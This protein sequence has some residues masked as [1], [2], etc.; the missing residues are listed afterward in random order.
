MS[1][2]GKSS[3]MSA[4]KVATITNS[5]LNTKMTF[6]KTTEDH[7]SDDKSEAPPHQLS[8]KEAVQKYHADEKHAR[9]F[10]PS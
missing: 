2:D 9:L 3:Q 10:F 6:T 5:F 4:G 1:K 7:P 8:V